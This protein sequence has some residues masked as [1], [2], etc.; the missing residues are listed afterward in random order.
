MHRPPRAPVDRLELFGRERL[1][2]PSWMHHTLVQRGGPSLKPA[3]P[4]NERTSRTEAGFG[5]EATHND[6]FHFPFID[7]VLEKLA[8]KSD[9]CFLDGFSRYMQIHI[10]LE[11]Q[12]KTT[13]TCPFGTFA[14]S[15]MPFGLCNAPSTFHYCMMS[16]FSDLL[17]DCMEVFMDDFTVYAN[18]F[19]EC[20][21]NLSKVLKR[22]ID[23]NL[24]LN[25]EKCHFLVTKGIVLGHLVSN[26][27][28]KV[29][30]SKIDI[31]SSLP[32]PT[33]VSEVFSFLGHAGFYRRFI[34]NFSKLALP[35]F[36]LLYKDVEFNFDQPCIEAF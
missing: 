6:H 14:Y 8:R 24:V 1:L 4:K 22:C 26:R 7:Q 31:I 28:I 29:D 25:F 10:A 23:T 15:R 27:G 20:L 21:G 34:M 17:E 11:D 3:C 32:N 19:D 35:L 30:K 9:Y 16:I 2:M 18:S 13:F 5:R 33:F 36:K 12:H